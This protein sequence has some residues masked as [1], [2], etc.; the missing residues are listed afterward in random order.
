VKNIQLIRVW[1]ARR[2]DTLL[3]SWHFATCVVHLIARSPSGEAGMHDRMA[4]T[5][6]VAIDPEP[7]SSL[8]RNAAMRRSCG[9]RILRPFHGI[10]TCAARRGVLTASEGSVRDVYDVYLLEA[11][12]AGECD[13]ED[14][15][16]G[17]AQPLWRGI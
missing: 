3:W 7:T 4:S 1:P 5:S 13:F 11:I 6:S 14:N 15:K 12:H 9:G 17:A 16:H 2:A 10:A 8:D